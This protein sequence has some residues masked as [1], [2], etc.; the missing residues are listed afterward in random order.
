MI[1]QEEHCLIIDIGKTNIKT[2]LLDDKGDIVCSDKLSNITQCNS[3]YP[4]FDI[5]QTWQWLLQ[6]IRKANDIAPIKAINVSTHGACAVLLQQN[7]ELALPV[8][9]YETPIPE[10]VSQEYDKIRPSFSETFSPKLP[11]GLNLG[12]QLYWMQQQYPAE[13]ANSET[14]LM[15]PQYWVWRLTG[16]AYTEVSSLGCH[17]DL[18]L[19]E[20]QCYS[21]LIDRLALTAKMPPIQAAFEVAGH[22]KQ[23]VCNTTSLSPDCR[24]YTGAHDSNAGF[25]RYLYA[26]P[27]SDI[28]VISTGTWIICMSA[29]QELKK[30]DENHDTLANV[31]VVGQCLPCARFMGGREFEKI[32]ELTR[33]EIDAVYSADDLQT[34]IY[35]KVFALPSFSAIGG[36][37]LGHMGQ[38]NAIPANGKALA[39]LYLALMIDYEL[40]LLGSKGDLVLGSSATKNPFLC[41]LLAQMRPHQQVLLSGDEATTIKGAWCLTR[42]NRPVEKSLQEFAFAEATNLKGLKAY[43]QCWRDKVKKLIL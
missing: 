34:V 10:I 24:V 22:P 39:T 3:D 43:R 14:L 5:Q 26:M 37:F 2:V 18:W 20:K 36:P 1:N 16:E 27:K 32:C 41:S 30:L 33:T 38:L 11:A 9:D 29:A 40:D 21:P 35:N 15:Y 7:G 42:W 19:P 6:S 31:S 23:D 17:T 28:T 13:F 4:F 12:R 25:A 8:L